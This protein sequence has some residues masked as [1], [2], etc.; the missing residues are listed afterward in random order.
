LAVKP[1][2]PISRKDAVVFTWPVSS[3]GAA[4]STTAPERR[5]WWRIRVAFS[6]GGFLPVVISFGPLLVCEV[7]SVSDVL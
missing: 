2:E 1:D 6:G 5:G 4:K 7:Q 3:G